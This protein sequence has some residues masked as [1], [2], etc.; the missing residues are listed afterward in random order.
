LVDIKIIFVS[1]VLMRIKNQGIDKLIELALNEDLGKGDVTS[2]VLINEN[3]RGKGVILAKEDGIL[4]GVEIARL[5]FKNIDPEVIF[6]SL[7]KD[8][9]KIRNKSKVAQL[10][11]KVK[12]I[13]AGERTALNFL[14]RLSGIA[15]LTSKF[16]KEV[17]GTKTKILD[18]RKTTP[19][20]RALE[21]YAVKMGGGENHRI[22]LYD[23]ILI[24]D[25]HIRA[26]GGVSSAIRKVKKS[27]K[28]ETFVSRVDLKNLKVEVETK[29]IEEVK[30]AIQSEADWIMLDNM[31]LSQIREGV[32]MIRSNKRKIRIEVSGEITLDKVRNIARLGVDFISVGALTHSAKALDLSLELLEIQ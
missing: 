4:A 12:S 32:R 27:L 20:F 30:E 15:T 10:E 22:G 7:I 29:N 23:R 25:N 11:G 8:G 31:S 13:L 1:F 14:Q 16:V 28:N 21:K 26:C 9:E 6:K 5:V 2:E 24:K 3:L 18:T 19:A 17:K